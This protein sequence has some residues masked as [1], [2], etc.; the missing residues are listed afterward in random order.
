VIG[1]DGFGYRP[2]ADGKSVL[3]IPHLGSVVLEDDV[4][5]GSGSMIDRG[6]F[7]ATRI[8]AGSKID[9]LCQVGHNVQMGRLCMVSGHTG[10][11]G[12]CNIGDRV[13]MGGGCG[14]G[15]HLTIGND[16]RIA[17]RLNQLAKMVSGVATI[18]NGDTSVDVT[19]DAALDGSPVQLTFAE[20]AGSAAK[21]FYVW[22]G[23]GVLS[24]TVDT[25]GPSLAPRV[26]ITDSARKVVF[27]RLGDRLRVAGMVELVGR[28]TRVIQQRIYS[29][30]HDTQ[31]LF[32][33]CSQWRDVLPWTGMRPATPTGLPIVGH[34]GG[35]RNL[36]INAGQGALG[37]TLAFGSATQLANTLC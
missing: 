28:D 7:A 4:E 2:S 8:G 5:I 31:V 35:P 13:H 14:I 6:K 15:P 3:R 30:Q 19:L 23:N 20:S 34:Q 37:F 25:D 27:A 22:D 33:D 10:I 29:L 32:G 17:A 16:V 21:L 1:G 24:I 11:A 12:S 26:S 18:A 36:F 9:N